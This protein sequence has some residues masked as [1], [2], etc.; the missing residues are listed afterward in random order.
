MFLCR[1]QTEQKIEKQRRAATAD[2][3]QRKLREYL[4]EGPT[5]AGCCKRVFPKA[6]GLK[7]MYPGLKE[8]EGG[9]R[10]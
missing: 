3:S 8:F 5:G 1:F 9:E 2:R 7:N 10:E 6:D 4:H